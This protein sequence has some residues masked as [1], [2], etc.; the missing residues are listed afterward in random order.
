M[1][2]TESTANQSS[3]SLKDRKCCQDLGF[4]F[5]GFRRWRFVAV[6]RTVKRDGKSLAP[7]VKEVRVGIAHTTPSGSIV[8]EGILAYVNRRG[9]RFQAGRGCLGE[10]LQVESL[11]VH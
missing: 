7:Q 8:I 2:G 10:T 4:Q 6:V 11:A 5:L 9:G 3:S 1:L